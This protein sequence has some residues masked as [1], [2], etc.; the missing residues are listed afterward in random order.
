M[1]ATAQL[2]ERERRFKQ[3]RRGTSTEGHDVFGSDQ[4]ELPFQKATAVGGFVRERRPVSWRATLEDVADVN[5][6][7][8]ETAC[9]DDAIQELAGGADKGQP[10]RVLVRTG[11]FPDEAQ[12]DAWYAIA[13]HGL[14]ARRTQLRTARAGFDFIRE[15]LQGDTAIVRVCVARG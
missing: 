14:R 2:A 8:R 4:F 7:A 10:L 11:R 6:F 15:G 13:E 9:R 1:K 12:L 3:I 5:F